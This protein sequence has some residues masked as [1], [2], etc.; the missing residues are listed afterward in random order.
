M[1]SKFCYYK[2]ECIVM[3]SFGYVSEMDWNLN[4]QDKKAS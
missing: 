2:I 1:F 3:F 4:T